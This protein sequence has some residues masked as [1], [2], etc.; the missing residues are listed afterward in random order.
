MRGTPSDRPIFISHRGNLDGVNPDR[1]NHPDYID[2]CLA[3]GYDC[4]IDL[5]FG[6]GSP[7][8]GH[9]TP[10]HK[11]SLEWLA[12][13][14]DRLWIHVKEYEALGW[15]M[16]NLP[17]ARYFCHESDRYTLVNGG[18][19]WCHD[20]QNSMNR[21]CIIPLL[22]KQSVADYDKRGFGGVCSDYLADCVLK[23][24]NPR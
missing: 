21:R 10:D 24:L 3:L 8:L 13:R 18:F 11:V 7:H 9:D 20:T 16:E 1:E 12:A 4:E 5:R 6:E 14:E 22:S 19:V 15:L 17:N 23:F 2:E